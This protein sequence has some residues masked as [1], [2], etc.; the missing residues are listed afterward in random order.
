LMTQTT[1]NRRRALAVVAAVPAAA[2]ISVPAL[3]NVGEDAELLRLWDE[4]KA[5]GLRC[6][7]PYEALSEIEGK[8]MH[9][10]GPFWEIAK[11]EMHPARALL[12]S[13]W[14]GDDRVKIV[15]LKAKDYPHAQKLAGKV[16]ADLAAERERCKKAAQRRYKQPAAERV[17]NLEYRRQGEIERK[18]A[19]TPAQGLK[20]LLVKLALWQ[21]YNRGASDENDHE[22]LTSAYE[23][24][25][26]LTGG[27]DLAAQVERW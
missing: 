15:P 13:S 12:I 19:E 5:Q 2:V 3:A 1:I 23:S 27:V 18:I 16:M 9:A 26:E 6:K 22:L 4:W 20:G 14:H 25:V 11:V 7:S 8:V 10:A 24:V 17:N 21:H